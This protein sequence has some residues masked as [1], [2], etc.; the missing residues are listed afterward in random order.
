MMN[1]LVSNKPNTIWKVLR[2]VFT[3]SL[4]LCQKSYSF[5]FWKYVNL[6]S[7]E[8]TVRPHFP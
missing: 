2:T 3:R 5:D 7:Y 4:F 1:V 8:N 6:D